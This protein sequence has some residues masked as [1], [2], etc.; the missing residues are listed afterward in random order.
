MAAAPPSRVGKRGE[1]RRPPAL[2]PT[3]NPPP[4]LLPLRFCFNLRA[5]RPTYHPVFL[6]RPLKSHNFQDDT[7]WH[8][9]PFQVVGQAR[10]VSF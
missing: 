6:T 10:S 7:H 3:I 9:P 8:H 4:P 2:I 5:S 1:Q